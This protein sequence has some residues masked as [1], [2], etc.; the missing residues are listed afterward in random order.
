MKKSHFV[1][2]HNFLQLKVS[3][4]VSNGLSK[5]ALPEKVVNSKFPMCS[6]ISLINTNAKC[7]LNLN[8]LKLNKWI[9]QS[10]YA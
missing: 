6:E 5:D 4:Q 3:V 1:N 8:M 10:I 2:D 7:T 9:N